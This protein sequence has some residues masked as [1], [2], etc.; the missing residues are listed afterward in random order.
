[1]EERE[2]NTKQTQTAARKRRWG[3]GYTKTNT[4]KPINKNGEA[5]PTFD[6]FI[7]TLRRNHCRSS[8]GPK[9]SLK[10]AF[11]SQRPRKKKGEL[12]LRD[13]SWTKKSK[14]GN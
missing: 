2:R 10:I 9:S 6:T 12:H 7:E 13:F 4:K 8:R 1:M 3:G 11:A 5:Q 14:S